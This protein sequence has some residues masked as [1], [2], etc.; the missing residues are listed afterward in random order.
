MILAA[1][2]GFDDPSA[3]RAGRDDLR[4]LEA[5]GRVGPGVDRVD[6][7]YGE[8]VH[9]R[10]VERAARRE[11]RL[12]PRRGPCPEPVGRAQ[13]SAG[14]GAA[15]ARTRLLASSMLMSFCTLRVNHL[16]TSADRKHSMTTR[17]QKPASETAMNT[18][19]C[20]AYGRCDINVTS[21]AGDG[22]VDRSPSGHPRSH[23]VG[24]LPRSR[25]GDRRPHGRADV[26]REE[27]S[28]RLPKGSGVR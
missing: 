22:R 25:G 9:A 14:S 13:L 5:H 20:E 12:S 2:F 28:Q 11:E 19:A 23:P 3:D 7:P 15:S 1:C 8:T 16:G 21:G 17:S 10:V 18:A 24:G 6:G 26:G 27:R 4:D